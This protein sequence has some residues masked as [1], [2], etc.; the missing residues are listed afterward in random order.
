MHYPAITPISN[1]MLLF[2][3]SSYIFKVG[4]MQKSRSQFAWASLSLWELC[5]CFAVQPQDSLILICRLYVCIYP[6]IAYK[7]LFAGIRR[8]Q[9]THGSIIGQAA[10]EGAGN[11]H[12]FFLII[13]PSQQSVSLKILRG[14]HSP[15]S[16]LHLVS[17]SSYLRCVMHAVT[18]TCCR[19]TKMKWKFLQLIGDQSTTLLE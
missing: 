9:S 11:G 2:F 18:P 4:T 13:S 10:H 6:L 5:L 16:L 15:C 17:F 3:G 12:V 19:F 7:M 14:W 1:G 8:C